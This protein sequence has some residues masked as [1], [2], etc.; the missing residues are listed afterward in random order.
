[1]STV[2][3]CACLVGLGWVLG[4]SAWGA[5]PSLEVEQCLQLAA[6]KYQLNYALLRS[7]AEQESGFKPKALS[8]ANKDGSTDYGLMQ[9]NDSWL[10]TLSKFGIGRDDLYKPCVN[11]DVGAWILFNNVQRLGLTWNAVGAYN[12]ST[13]W[14]RVKYANGVYQRLQRHL[15]SPQVYG[16]LPGPV[17]HSA[18]HR[19]N[20]LAN[21][22]TGGMGVWEHTRT[23]LQSPS[24][25]S[26]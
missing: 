13:P 20:A 3:R 15:T 11:A 24:E 25:S 18:V 16:L 4:F 2:R 17:T 14:K 8:G 12:A 9:I 7:I 23:A 22:S 26:P 5:E 10:P 21:A 19:P 1:M 6:Y